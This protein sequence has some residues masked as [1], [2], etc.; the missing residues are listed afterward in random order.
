MKDIYDRFIEE[1]REEFERDAGHDIKPL[2]QGM[3]NLYYSQ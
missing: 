2:S 1:L 3:Y